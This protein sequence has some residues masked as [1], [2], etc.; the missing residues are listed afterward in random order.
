[1]PKIAFLI[2]L[3]CAFSAVQAA[4]LLPPLPADS[5]PHPLTGSWAWKLPGK[6]CS[7]TLIYRQDGSRSG[8]SGDE[9]MQT[10][11]EVSDKPSLLGFYRLAETVTASNGKQDCSGDVH[12]VSAAPVV[13]FIQF[14]PKRDQFIACKEEALKACFGPLKRIVN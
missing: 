8:T 4:E 11:Y 5:S 7:E 12:T 1:M 9:V 2:A 6:A 3:T 13:R 10:R 14:S